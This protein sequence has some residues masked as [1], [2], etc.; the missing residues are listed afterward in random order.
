MEAVHEDGLLKENACV[1]IIVS[2]VR[3]SFGDHTHTLRPRGDVYCS[4]SIYYSY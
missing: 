3:W 2:T 4:Q 1:I